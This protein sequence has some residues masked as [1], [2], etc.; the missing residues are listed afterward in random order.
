MVIPLPFTK[1]IEILQWVEYISV[2]LYK[3]LHKNTNKLRENGHTLE[4]FFSRH[5]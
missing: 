3:Y 5:T 2:M 4:S 1:V